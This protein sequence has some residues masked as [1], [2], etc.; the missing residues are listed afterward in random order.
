MRKKE[1]FTK[2]TNWSIFTT[3]WINMQDAYF[4]EAND[5]GDWVKIGY[6]APGAAN[7]SNKS[8]FASNTFTYDGNNCG[9]GTACTWT[10]TP[11]TK[12]NDCLPSESE[13]WSM[14]A[15]TSGD[16][17][18]GKYTAFTIAD[19]DTDADCKTLTA[20]WDNLMGSHN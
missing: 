10:A 1:S 3:T 2:K 9:S 15:T 6:T 13:K 5:V 4:Q 18:N 8:S 17:G 14:S 16:N 19:N 12:L 20:S 11:K 7:P